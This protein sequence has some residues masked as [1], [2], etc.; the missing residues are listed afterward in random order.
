[1]VGCIHDIL[2]I[3]IFNALDLK[4]MNKQIY[5]SS[6]MLDVIGWYSFQL[7]RGYEAAL[8][9]IIPNSARI[10]KQS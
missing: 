7:W 6:D 9:I 2:H 8:H 1:M 5:L 3:Y 4:Q 10:K